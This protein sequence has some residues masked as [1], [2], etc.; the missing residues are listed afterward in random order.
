MKKQ[1]LKMNFISKRTLTHVIKN[2]KRTQLAEQL[3]SNAP[4]ITYEP[5]NDKV[6]NTAGNF[7]VTIAIAFIKLGIEQNRR[8]LYRNFLPKFFLPVF[9]FLHFTFHKINYLFCISYG[10][11]F[12][13]LQ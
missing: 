11:I 13:M 5:E 12:A 9:V 6:C 10:K 8:E 3:V 1:P 2:W 7:N 4:N